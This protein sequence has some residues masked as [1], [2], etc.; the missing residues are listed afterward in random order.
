MGSKL[1]TERKLERKLWGL[2]S[3][4]PRALPG[5]ALVLVGKG[6]M[7][8]LYPDRAATTG[9]AVWGGY[10]TVYEV[11]MGHKEIAFTCSAPA[12]GGDVAFQVNFSA[13]YRVNDPGAVIERRIED[14]EPIIKRVV[15]DAISQ[16]TARFD[17]EKVQDASAAVRELLATHNFTDQIPFV[18][19]TPLA[20]LELDSKAKEYLS[21]RREMRRQAELARHSSDLTV[22]TADAERLKREYELRAMKQQQEGEIEIARI[23]AEMEAELARRKTELELEIQKRRLEV[24]KPMIEGGMWG[25]LAQQL[26]QNPDDIGRVTE[27]MLQAQNQKVQADV[28]MLKALLDSDVI[29]DRHLKDVTA[30]LVRNLEQNLRGAPALGPGP[31]EARRLPDASTTSAAPS[32]APGETTQAR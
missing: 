8:V 32:G 30:S 2:L 10:D 27:L 18:L 29:E 7:V 6:G 11:D 20:T 26:A 23:K 25:L 14:P 22:A 4:R 1:Y 28:L 3:E 9:E 19:D 5:Q 16:V 12:E 31:S 24:Y 15:T 13:G 21:K 17:I